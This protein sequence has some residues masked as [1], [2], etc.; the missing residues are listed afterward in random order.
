MLKSACVCVCVCVCVLVCVRVGKCMCAC[1]CAWACVCT[2]EQV[3]LCVYVCLCVHDACTLRAVAGTH[4]AHT[5]TPNDGGDCGS[6]ATRDKEREIV[7]ERGEIC[8]RHKSAIWL[9]REELVYNNI[10][11]TTVLHANGCARQGREKRSY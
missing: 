10:I 5:F 3:Y 1:T 9:A 11:F 8:R 2:S 7:R 6:R 4:D